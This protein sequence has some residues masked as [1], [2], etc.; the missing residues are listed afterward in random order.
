[1][2][3]Q[4]Q[5]SSQGPIEIA[6]SLKQ[7]EML[8]FIIQNQIKE[9]SCLGKEKNLKISQWT[10]KEN[11]P[12]R[13]TL[14]API[15]FATNNDNRPTGPAPKIRTFELMPMFA[16]LQACTPTDNG[17]NNAPSANVTLS[18]NL[19]RKTI[20]LQILFSSFTN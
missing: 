18:G 16:R 3:H 11:I 2:L 14:L 13:T 7:I 4:L 9:S 20:L 10:I 12:V 15:A 19:Q 17:S 5:V 8:Y 6:T 1:M